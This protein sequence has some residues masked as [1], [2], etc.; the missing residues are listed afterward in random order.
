MSTTSYSMPVCTTRCS[1]PTAASLLPVQPLVMQGGYLMSGIM[2]TKLREAGVSGN[3]ASYP[4][5]PAALTTTPLLCL[6]P[7]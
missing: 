1:E 5:P 7:W 2:L 6:R 4:L 3:L